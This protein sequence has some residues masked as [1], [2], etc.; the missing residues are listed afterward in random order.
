[1]K[2]SCTFCRHLGPQIL[3]LVNTKSQP[4]GKKGIIFFVA[5]SKWILSLSKKLYR[6]LF[7]QMHYMNIEK[8]RCMH[9]ISM[10]FF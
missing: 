4:N 2:K 1:M 9:Y 5:L 8:H 10:N 3:S 7:N 6:I